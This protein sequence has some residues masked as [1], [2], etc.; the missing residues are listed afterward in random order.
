MLVEKR[1]KRVLSKWLQENISLQTLCEAKILRDKVDYN[2]LPHRLKT[3]LQT[4]YKLFV[5]F[6]LVC[7]FFLLGV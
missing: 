6:Y 5:F 1:L 4:A 3:K 2:C 7:N